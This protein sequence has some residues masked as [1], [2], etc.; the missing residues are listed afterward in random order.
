[1][2]YISFDYGTKNIG[3]AIGQKITNTGNML[4]SIKIKNGI[5]NWK[6][7]KKIIKYWNPKSIVIGLPLNMNGTEQNFTVKTKNFAINIKKKFNIPVYMHDER[8]TTVEAKNILFRKKGKKNLTKDK[9]N[10]MSALIIL[11]SWMSKN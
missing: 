4:P 8:L 10:S 1:M 3:L 11:E 2:N 6:K 9:I 5:I 7:I